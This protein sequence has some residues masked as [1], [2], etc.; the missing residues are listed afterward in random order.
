MALAF[1]FIIVGA[2]SAGCVLAARLSE[3]P[4]VTVLLLEAGGPDYCWDWRLH[5]PAALTY[6]LKSRRYNWGYKTEPMPEMNN[7]VGN[8]YR[9]KVLGGS[10]SINGMVYQRG[11]ALDFDG[12]AEDRALANWNYAGVLPYFRR[13]ETYDQGSDVYRGG[14][15]PLQVTKGTGFSPLYQVFIEAGLQAGYPYTDDMN[16]RQQEGFGRIDLTIAHGLRQSTARC[17]LRPAMSRGN[18]TVRTGALALRILFD[19]TRATG[20]EYA[21]GR[22]RETALSRREVLIAGGAINSPQLLL[23]SGIGPAA[24]LETLKIP[25][26]CNLAGVGENLQDHVE[27]LMQHECTKPVTLFDASKLRHKAMIGAQWLFSKTGLGSTNHFETGGF[28]RSAPD[29]AWPDIQY[30]FL[31]MAVAYDG[32]NAAK[33]HGFQ[34]HVG[35]MRSKSRGRIRLRSADPTVAPIITANWMTHSNDWV[36]MRQAIRLTREIFAQ[37]AFNPY[38]GAEIAPGAGISQDSD[39]DAFVRA[40]ADSGYH[41]CGTCKMGSDGNAVVD[42]SLK[43]HGVENLRV[44]DASVMPLIPNANTNAASIMIGEKGSDLV[45]GCELPPINAPVFKANACMQR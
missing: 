23:L 6:P 44:I 9:G 27:V 1:D 18:L 22:R 34:V 11:N 2:G 14:A 10:S 20:V 35:P 38:R 16:G 40:S 5:M 15:G 39:L 41:Y 8:W 37:K 43:V 24:H 25:I 4:Q 42:A 17:Y 30:H 7:R 19:G 45:R 21:A 36:E 26:V 28:V 13:S 33:A 32:R 3:D 31:A 12:W 29:I